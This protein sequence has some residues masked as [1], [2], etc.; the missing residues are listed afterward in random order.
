[1]TIHAFD[2]DGTLTRRD[3]ML[4]FI[5]YAKGDKATVLGFLKHLHLI[6][7]MML[8]I[9]SHGKTKR[10]IFQYFFGGMGTGSFNT[11][12]E[13]FAMDNASILSPKGCRVVQ[14]ALSKGYEVV[15]ITASIENWVRPFF[16]LPADENA[17]TVMPGKV[18]VIGTRLQT[19]GG[20]ITGE[21]ATKNCR[22]EEKV[23]R[24]LECYPE[25]T[26]YKLIVYGDSNGDRA[27]LDFSDEGYYRT[28]NTEK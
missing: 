14:S 22:G 7:L 8:G 12:C 9:M 16:G 2:F 25:R 3:S 24:L 6:I 27:L 15:V 11:L 17:V 18:R 4:E 21:F 13:R 10:I 20:I 19:A 5:R 1:M 26:S 23:R 28:F